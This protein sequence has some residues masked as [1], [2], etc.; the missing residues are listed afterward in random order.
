MIVSLHDSRLRLEIPTANK[1]SAAATRAV[2]YQVA[3]DLVGKPPTSHLLRNL[4]ARLYDLQSIPPI[5]KATREMVKKAL[6]KILESKNL[7]DAAW[8]EYERLLWNPASRHQ[9]HPYASCHCDSHTQ[10]RINADTCPFDRNKTCPFSDV[11]TVCRFD[12]PCD[13][14]S[15]SLHV[16][17]LLWRDVALAREEQDLQLAISRRKRFSDD[18]L[19]L[20]VP[21]FANVLFL[22]ANTELY[23]A[24]SLL[25][26]SLIGGESDRNQ[27]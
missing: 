21:N 17:A 15:A 1:G 9:I 14:I 6:P 23:Q 2:L 5:L 11:Y 18:H 27:P 12:G 8:H 3:S 7:L 10:K 26:D 4:L 19:A 13:H 20:W 24:V 16:A 22:E 25:I